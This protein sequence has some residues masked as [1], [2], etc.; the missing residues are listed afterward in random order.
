MTG[1][2]GKSSS[3]NRVELNRAL[4]TG[5]STMFAVGLVLGAGIYSVIAQAVAGAGGLT[6]LPFAV[7]PAIIYLFIGLTYAEFAS[8][9]PSAGSAYVY[10]RAGLSTVSKRGGNFVSFIM[11]FSGLFVAIPLAAAVVALVF[12]QYLNEFLATLGIGFA[13]VTLGGLLT[14]DP[15]VIFAVIL[16]LALTLINWLGIKETAVAM[17]LGTI[18]EV[19]GLMVIAFLGFT[20][21]AINPNYLSTSG[22]PKPGLMGLITTFAIGYFMYSGLELTPSLAEEAKDPHKTI[23]R[24][25]MI[26]LTVVAAIYVLVALGIV[27]LLPFATLASSDAPFIKASAVVIGVAT[28]TLLFAFF[29][30]FAALNTVLAELVTSSRLM[31]GIAD[32]GALPSGLATVGRSRRTPTNAIILAGVLAAVFCL[33]EEISLVV[34]GAVVTIC[35]IDFIVA[36]S[37][38]ASRRRAPDAKRPFKVPFS[39]KRVPIPTLLAAVVVFFLP[40]LL[41]LDNWITW[42]PF[43]ASLPI[44][45]IV[46]VALNRK[47]KAVS[48]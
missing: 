41:L 24:A 16:V 26:S 20:S 25:I 15:P 45:T 28:A 21:G 11:L 3:T 46:Y 42:I 37:L 44:A 32:Q 27:R 29:A 6:W 31:Y 48:K 7:L 18:V 33:F 1:K 22:A 36:L 43:L 14:I 5:L 12:G 17:V 2:K 19:A 38:I 40:M 13:P 4:G 23:P 8:M 35:W 34:K 39:V 10:A 9:Y 47:K 30:L